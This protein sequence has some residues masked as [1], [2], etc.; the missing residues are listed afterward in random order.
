MARSF[1]VPINTILF[2]S[3]LHR[4][5]ERRTNTVSNSLFTGYSQSA[6]VTRPEYE[7]Y[8][9]AI[10]INPNSLITK[11]KADS[12]KSRLCKSDLMESQ[13]IRFGLK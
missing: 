9:I 12:R 6:L 10:K 7:A 8:N 2:S 11:K 1:F 3:Y 5:H 4:L 13:M